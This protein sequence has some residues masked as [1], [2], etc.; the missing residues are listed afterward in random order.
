MKIVNRATQ[1]SEKKF[2]IEEQEPSKSQITSMKIH[3]SLGTRIVF[4]LACGIDLGL[5]SAII[6]ALCNAPS[7]VESIT[8]VVV[9]L[10]STVFLFQATQHNLSPSSDNNLTNERMSRVA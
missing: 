10:V 4:S 2:V 3:R 9:S 8:F 5:A 1:V 6:C 7:S